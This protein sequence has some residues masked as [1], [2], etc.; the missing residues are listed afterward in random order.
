MNKYKV[1]DH[2]IVTGNSNSHEFWMGQH[3]RIIALPEDEGGYECEP[4][5]PFTGNAWYVL[6]DE[7]APYNPSE[8]LFTKNEVRK[9]AN[10]VMNLGMRHR[11]DQLQME[12]T[13]SGNEVLEEYLNKFVNSQTDDKK[14]FVTDLKARIEALV[15]FG[16]SQ[17]R[18][19][20]IFDIIDDTFNAVIPT[21][22][23]IL[24]TE[25][26]T[27]NKNRNVK[28]GDKIF[29]AGSYY[30]VAEITPGGTMIGIFDEPPSKHIDYINL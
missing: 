12:S 4:I 16:I 1:G 25:K 14:T 5:G 18:K 26:D 20:D 30:E 24:E 8:R 10:E 9:I 2:M 28:P 21:E 3:I 23:Q 11:Q 27:I 15:A 13:K 22:K 17:F 19:E 7:M 29:F 6:E